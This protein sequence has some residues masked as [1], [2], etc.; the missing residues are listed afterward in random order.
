MSADLDQSKTGAFGFPDNFDFDFQGPLGLGDL[1]TINFGNY[2]DPS[3][4][5]LMGDTTFDNNLFFDDAYSNLFAVPETVGKPDGAPKKSLIAQI[6]AAKEADEVDPTNKE[7]NCDS[8]WCDSTTACPSSAHADCFDREKLNTCDKAKNADFDLDGLC[9]DLQKKAKCSGNGD[10]TTVVD[11]KVFKEVLKKY[12]GDDHFS[13]E[14]EEDM[15]KA[16]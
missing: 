1:D 2:R 3:A 15:D 10:N 5:F 16:G 6:D 8:I 9:K 14:C 7:L 12:L 13:K 11:Q 4:N